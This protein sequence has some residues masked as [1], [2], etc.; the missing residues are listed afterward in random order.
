M[1]T[2]TNY[3]KKES[4]IM[5]EKMDSSFVMCAENSSNKKQLSLKGIDIIK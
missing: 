4:I 1:R 3:M 5:D 2:S